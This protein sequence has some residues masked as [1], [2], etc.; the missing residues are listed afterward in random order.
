MR[1]GKD[2]NNDGTVDFA[3]GAPDQNGF[4]GVAYIFNGTNGSLQRQLH[5]APQM[6]AKFGACVALSADISGDGR[7]DILVGA[8]DQTVNGLL[9]AGEAFV[10]RGANGK[11]FKTVTSALLR[12][13]AGFGSV[14]TT[15][16]FNGDGVPE[17]VIGT[18]FQDADLIDP[19][20]DLVTHLQI[21]QIEIQ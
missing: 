5:A 9:N 2:L 10:F 19:D 12:A 13:F 8:P 7:P 21:G 15:A 14:I 16:D 17:T 1:A 11:L 4:K 3:V 18:P 20:G 6:F